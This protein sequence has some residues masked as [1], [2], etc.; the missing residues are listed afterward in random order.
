MNF[1]AMSKGYFEADLDLITTYDGN[2]ELPFHDTVLKKVMTRDGSGFSLQPYVN[3]G[4]NL[5]ST[6]IKK[7]VRQL[8]G[9]G[10]EDYLISL[11]FYDL[12]G[13]ELKESVS[14]PF[15]GFLRIKL[16][17]AGTKFIAEAV[18]PLFELMKTTLLASPLFFNQENAEKPFFEE[19]IKECINLL[20]STAV[21][22]YYVFWQRSQTPKDLR[23]KKLNQEL[24]QAAFVAGMSYY[25]SKR[26]GLEDCVQIALAAFLKNAGM[27]EFLRNLSD[28]K[29][30]FAM[31]VNYTTDILAS[32]KLNEKILDLILRQHTA[33]HEDKDALISH[34]VVQIAEAL[35]IYFYGGYFLVG[36]DYVHYKEGTSIY[37]AA[38]RMVEKSVADNDSSGVKKLNKS[39]TKENAYAEHIIFDENVVN[40]VLRLMGFGYLISKYAHIRQEITSLCPHVVIF[41]G[42]TSVGCLDDS[43]QE[44]L[45]NPLCKGKDSVISQLAKED[46]KLRFINLKCREGCKRLMEI[47]RIYY[48]SSLEA[49]PGLA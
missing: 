8:M 33:L 11:K 1:K 19:H 29:S 35:Y 36:K 2:C 42:L 4:K 18:K 49:G 44:I 20:S 28:V 40:K 45:S 5:N 41:P 27:V 13:E 48:D 46:G 39:S 9:S 43:N 16:D 14:V 37:N 7:F 21:A 23:N 22:N 17:D 26:I 15:P 25:F 24:E 10:G 38:K 31:K 32:Y 3:E 34:K 47:N 30:G 6:S 12:E